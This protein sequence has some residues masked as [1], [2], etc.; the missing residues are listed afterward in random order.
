[1]ADALTYWRETLAGKRISV[2][3]DKPQPGFYFRRYVRNGPRLPVAIHLVNHLDRHGD[4]IC[5]PTIECFLEGEEVDAD[6]VWP[7]CAKHAITKEEHDHLISDRAWLVK[8][9]PNGPE[10]DPGVPVNL[11]ELD[12]IF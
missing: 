2:I 1:M 8:Y 5:D 12:P 3:A 9:D 4:P 10:T 6:R 11:R 7:N